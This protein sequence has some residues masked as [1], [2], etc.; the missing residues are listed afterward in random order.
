MQVYIGEKDVRDG[1][2]SMAYWESPDVEQAMNVLFR[3]KET[4]KIDSIV[5]SKDGIKAK[6]INVPVKSNTEKMVD[7]ANQVHEEIF[8]ELKR[9]DSFK[10]AAAE[11]GIDLV[12]RIG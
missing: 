8:Q 4:E 6:F 10:K 3:V 7:Y 2:M 1:I 9:L 12:K 5:I 11:A